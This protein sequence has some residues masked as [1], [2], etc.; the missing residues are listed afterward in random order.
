MNVIDRIAS[1]FGF[2]KSAPYPVMSTQ[3]VFGLDRIGRNGSSPRPGIGNMDSA[4]GRYADE[5]WVYSCIRIIQTK[6]A[7]VP[8]KVYKNVNGKKIEQPD[9]PLKKLLD[10]VNPFMD[11]YDLREGTHGFRELAGNALWLLDAFDGD[12]LPTE[13]YP[14]SPAHMKPIILKTTGLVGFEYSVNGTDK[15]KFDTSEVIHFKNWNP[16][17][18]FWGL[19]PISAGRDG[20]DMMK[21][22]DQYNVAFFKNG[23]EAG[24]FLT[25]DKPMQ[26]EQADIIKEAWDKNHRGARKSHRVE[27]LTGGLK[28]EN[29]TLSHSDMLFPELKRMSREEVLTCYGIPPVMVGV[30]DE[31]NYS[32]ADVQERI[33][34]KSCILPRLRSIESVL[35]E[36]LAKPFGDVI[37]EHDTSGIAE[38][39]EN[40]KAKA[41]RD[42]IHIETGIRTVNEIRAEMNLPPV[43]WG[44]EPPAK[45]T[46]GVPGDPFNPKPPK[47]KPEEDEEEDEDD[48][49]G[50]QPKPRTLSVEEKGVLRRTK[51][52]YTF[53]DQT[54]AME[55][56]W[57]PVLRKLFVGQLR[58]V[59]SNLRSHWKKTV[60]SNP[61]KDPR[62]IKQDISV[63]LFEGGAARR[64]F[65]KEGRKLIEMALSDKARQEIEDYD[66]GVQFQVTN[67][68]VTAAIRE[69][70]FQFAQKV[71]E[72]TEAALREALTEA[73]KAG[74][75]IADVEKR[76]EDIFGIARGARTEMIART[77]V[78]SASNQGAVAAYEQSG[79]VEGIEWVSS[80]DSIVRESHQIDGDVV[81]LKGDDTFKNGLKFPGDPAA[82]PEE[83]IQCRCTTAPVVNKE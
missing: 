16:L 60:F 7:S 37:V 4:L 19:P 3:S 43:A 47:P 42:Q 59:V 72:T 68:E 62:V 23:A 80:R 15:T 25:T 78:V 41:E 69:R 36:R 21:A 75:S 46:F 65:Q 76:I 70:A 52:W 49:K 58:E 8:L 44:N 2:Q 45:P 81:S 55:R 67:P 77:E 6:A 9:H 11:G 26:K 30:F 17:D 10:S 18:P 33:F 61:T 29:N 28:W 50:A 32:N 73:I 48:E 39:Q 12:A 31:A 27:V 53:K 74:D 22:A 57:H 51:A 38:L 64:L 71:N 40:A 79:V 13:I 14:L 5:A 24:G 20:A 66:L 83:I 82:P 1:A 35:N 63:I 34:W 54:E 56:R